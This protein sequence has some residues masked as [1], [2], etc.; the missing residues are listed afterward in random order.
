[1]TD[2][3]VY[4]PPGVYVTET[5]QPLVGR[6]SAST[7]ITAIVGPSVGYRTFTETVTLPGTTAVALSQRGVVSGSVV[8]TTIGGVPLVNSDDYDIT[9]DSAADVRDR[10][11]SIARDAAGDIDSGDPVRVAYRYVDRDFNEPLI[12]R[13]YDEAESAFGEAFANGGGVLSPLTLAAKVAMDNGSGPLMLVATAGAASQTTLTNAMEKLEA[14]LDVAIVVP[15]PV[16][17]VGT[18][19]SP[20]ATITTG[21]A[22]RQ[23]VESMSDQGHYRIGIYGTEVEATVAPAT[24]AANVQSPRI[25]VAHPNKMLYFNQVTSQTVTIAGYYLAA[26]YAGRFTSQAVELPL[27]RRAIVGFAGISAEA[28]LRVDERNTLSASGV[29]VAEV[30]RQRQL[31]CRHGVSTDTFTFANREISVIRARDT[32]MRIIEDTLE[33]SSVIGQVVSAETPGRIRAIVEGG[34]ESLQARGVFTSYRE[35]AARQSQSDPTVIEVKF[36]YLPAYPL[37]YVVVAF[38]I[39]ADTG[40]TTLAAA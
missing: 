35:L 25:M 28:A 31:V 22:L 3:S 15:L 38:N 17:M 12:V 37:N 18:E 39:D 6:V 29:A 30:N 19:A 13:S 16:G 34:L 5:T 14:Y 36:Q 7:T 40:Q 20:G 33:A 26:A 1:M 32:M 23:H 2:F 4:Q 21:Q 8:V 11:T 24:I 10:I 27:T 9:V